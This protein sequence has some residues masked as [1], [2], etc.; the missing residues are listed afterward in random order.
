MFIES[1]KDLLYIVIAFCILWITIFT[2]WFIYYLAMIMRQI[3]K[4]IK[5]TRKKFKK[6]DDAIHNFKEKLDLSAAGI[7]MVGEGVKKVIDMVKE[8]SD[9]KEKST[10]KK[11]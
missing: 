4:M 7:S 2:A 11:K 8:K 9:K 10:K 3:L 5:D 6:V 1:S